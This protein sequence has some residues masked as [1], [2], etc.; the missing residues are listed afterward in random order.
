MVGTAPIQAAP[1]ISGEAMSRV[2][3]S[4]SFFTAGP[5]PG[6]TGACFSISSPMWSMMRRFLKSLRQIPLAGDFRRGILSISR[7]MSGEGGGA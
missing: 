7:S 3:A 6:G 1:C 2:K 5:K 4:P